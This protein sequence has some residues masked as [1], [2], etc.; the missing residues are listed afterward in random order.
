MRLAALRL[1]AV[2]LYCLRFSRGFWQPA[3][4]FVLARTNSCPA[5]PQAARLARHILLGALNQIKGHSR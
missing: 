4:R 5:G 2:R 1:L 3:I